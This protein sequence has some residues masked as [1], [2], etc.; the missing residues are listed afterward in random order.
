MNK[1]IKDLKKRLHRVIMKLDAKKAVAYFKWKAR[2][3]HHN[4]HE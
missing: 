2:F 1:I 3:K 4:K